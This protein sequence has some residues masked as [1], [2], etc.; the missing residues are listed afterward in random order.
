[1]TGD[2]KA[3][4]SRVPQGTLGFPQQS[5]RVLQSSTEIINYVDE[6]TSAGGSGNNLLYFATKLPRLAY[7][8][9]GVDKKLAVHSLTNLGIQN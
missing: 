6:T 2:L 8:V 5:S 1:M 4:S 3:G 7:V 9:V